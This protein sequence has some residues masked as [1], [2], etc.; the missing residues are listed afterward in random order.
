[1][2]L[3]FLPLDIEVTETIFSLG[4]CFTHKQNYWET[5]HVIGKENNYQE[6]RSLLDQIPIINMQM[7]THKIQQTEVIPHYDYHGDLDELYKHFVENEPAGYHIVLKGK[8]D[9]LEVFNGKKWITPILPKVPI[10]YLLNLTSCIHRVK[11]DNLRET[12][13][14]QG[15]LNIEKH[16]QLIERSL[17]R[18][19]DLAIYNQV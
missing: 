11:K 1:M 2:K 4:E 6:Y 7:F 3:L 9:A 16:N 5:K 19:G 15:L 12:L 14:L 17:K 10:A 13:Y 8:N 18:Y